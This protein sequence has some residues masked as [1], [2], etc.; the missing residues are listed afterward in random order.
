[1]HPHSPLI[2]LMKFVLTSE[3]LAQAA[4]EQ[5]KL[6]GRKAQRVVP[7]RACTEVLWS[8]PRRPQTQEVGLTHSKPTHLK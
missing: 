3:G 5:P 1:M 6:V 8:E 7:S 4:W 2:S